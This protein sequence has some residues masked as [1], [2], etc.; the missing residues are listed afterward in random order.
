MDLDQINHQQRH[1]VKIGNASLLE[2]ELLVS[3][4][5]VR[6]LALGHLARS[7]V[8]SS[9]QLVEPLSALNYL[10]VGAGGDVHQMKEAI[11]KIKEKSPRLKIILADSLENPCF[12]SRAMDQGNTPTG[13]DKIIHI[14]NKLVEVSRSILHHQAGVLTGHGGGLAGGV[15]FMLA[16]KLQCKTTVAFTITNFN[17]NMVDQLLQ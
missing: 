6:F 14:P 10:V 9:T 3:E 8:H 1:K 12:P 16:D 11:R 2:L 7:F 13:V 15:A 5:P 4:Q 17:I